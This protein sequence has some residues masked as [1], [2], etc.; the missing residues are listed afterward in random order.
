MTYL[1]GY[2]SIGITS[3]GNNEQIEV[4]ISES[5]IPPYDSNNRYEYHLI[6]SRYKNNK[7]EGYSTIEL[8]SE[9]IRELLGF[10]G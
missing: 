10:L 6:L 2:M 1:Q 5:P 8:P 3:I 4:G 9:I 7:Q